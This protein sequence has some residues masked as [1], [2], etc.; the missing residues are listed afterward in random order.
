MMEIRNAVLR[1]YFIHFF[2]VLAIWMSTYFP[3]FDIFCAVLYIIFI[4]W[5]IRNLYTWK[6]G[7]KFISGL[8]WLIPPVLLALIAKSN[9]VI[10]DL[11]NLSFFVL[12]LWYTP[13]I[14]L[15]SLT[16][17]HHIAGLW[18]TSSWVLTMPCIMAVHYV[19][20]SMKIIG[21]NLSLPAEHD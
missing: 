12:Q 15:V 13:F 21:H 1:L 17:S 11:S 4:S 20:F 7:K 8:C 10:G 5:E 14:P 19:V 3:G 2:A 9:I 18:W 16:T 6:K